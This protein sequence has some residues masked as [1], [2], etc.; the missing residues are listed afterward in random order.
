[1]SVEN[2][3][4]NSDTF[5]QEQAKRYNKF[6]LADVPY[7][8]EDARQIW[9]DSMMRA[10]GL[11][12]ADNADSLVA[13]IEA[14]ETTIAADPLFGWLAV[15]GRSVL[16]SLD[17]LVVPLEFSRFF[18][19]HFKLRTVT[20]GLSYSG[21]H[22]QY[23]VAMSTLKDKNC[24]STWLLFRTDD[25]PYD[26]NRRIARVSQL[27]TSLNLDLSALGDF[28]SKPSGFKADKADQLLKASDDSPELWNLCA[29]TFSFTARL[30]AFLA[31]VNAASAAAGQVA[32]DPMAW[33]KSVMET[34]RA[35]KLAALKL[36]PIRFQ[37]CLEPDFSAFLA[38]V[39]L[40]DPASTVGRLQA[41]NIW[42]KL[43]F[44]MA[45][46]LKFQPPANAPP[47]QLRDYDRLYNAHAKLDYNVLA[48]QVQQRQRAAAG[49]PTAETQA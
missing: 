2:L 22:E 34:V 27:L 15:P 11:T 46:V 30:S 14:I 4:R 47:A 45:S 9:R 31:A 19:K 13:D 40:E 20:S 39:G 29:N 8:K 28:D 6:N 24:W 16:D 18:L 25:V 17:L 10:C 12:T 32:F 37:P 48:F 26:R 5:F 44:E 43:D 35:A 1:M 36:K 49:A 3:K 42:N 41:A 23:E 38:G 21:S 7:S 33:V